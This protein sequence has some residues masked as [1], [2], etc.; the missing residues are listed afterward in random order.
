LFIEQRRISASTQCL[1][2]S[3]IQIQRLLRN[4]L[5]LNKLNN[6]CLN[7]SDEKRYGQNR[8]FSS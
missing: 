3:R 7:K 6:V 1:Q 2:T 5:C 8:E 4:N